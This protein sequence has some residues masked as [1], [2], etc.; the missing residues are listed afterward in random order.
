[1]KTKW[2]T[3]V[4][5]FIALAF[6]LDSKRVEAEGTFTQ[7]F[8]SVA[9]KAIP[10]VVF[11]Q[12]EKQSSPSPLFDGR[13]SSPLFQDDFFEYFFGRQQQEPKTVK[14][15]GS[16]FIVA[17]DGYILTNNHV[18]QDQ[19]KLTVKLSDGREFTAKVIGQ[20][21]ATD[22]AVLRIE[23][24]GLPTLGLGNSDT[25]EVGQWVVAIG[26]PL[27][28]QETLTVG[29]VS[30]KGRSNLD[31]AN[32]EDFIQ[33]DA[34]INRGN[35]GGPLLDIDG[36]VVGINTA[37]ISSMGGY[38]GIGFAIPSNMASRVMQ[39]LI[40]KGSV[41]RGYLGVV[42]QPLDASLATAFHLKNQEGALVA[43]TLPD[44]PAAKAGMQAGDVILEYNG[45]KVANVASFR[46]AVAMMK[47]NDTL[48][49]KIKREDK[50]LAIDVTIDALSKEKA[51]S[52]SGK[53]WGLDVQDLTEELAQKLSVSVLEG[54]V[55]SKV[56]KESVADF[57]GI[58]P[59]AVV[60]SVNKK[61]VNSSEEFQQ[62]IALTPKSAPLLL[63]LR[64]G[65][66]ARYVSLGR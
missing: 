43:E 54:V 53:Q 56:E 13:P 38:T 31:I 61:P 48:H 66:I 41:T 63:Y 11:I 20:D 45:I 10:A 42:L 19:K 36:D 14:S 58:K 39:E 18:V 27:G 26:N 30:A 12:A 37:I 62:A 34:S 60:L 46:N 40:E 65:K 50:L 25:L 57:A 64:Q 6:F 4:F 44:T 28:F 55:V 5:L 16:G 59:G 17:E 51:V 33:T 24:N 8:S 49:L 47:P 15:S 29:V 22:L 21:P 2:M 1:M 32:F 9:K 23:A 3:N 35:S 7:G 52:F